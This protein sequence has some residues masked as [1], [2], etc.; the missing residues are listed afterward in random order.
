LSEPEITDTTATVT[1]SDNSQSSTSAPPDITQI[2]SSYD[3][4][5]EAYCSDPPDLNP[6]DNIKFNQNQVMGK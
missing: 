5:S 1:D 2:G 4:E 3:D 6:E